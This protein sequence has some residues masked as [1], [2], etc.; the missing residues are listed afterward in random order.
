MNLGLLVLRVVVGLLFAGHG[1]QKLFGYFGGYGLK[2]TA[3]FFEGIG[4]KPGHVHATS[5]GIMEFGGGLL[6]ALG[7]ITP[8]ASAALIA[9]MTAA[10]ITVHFPKGVWVT[11]GGYEYNLVLGAVAFALA[12][13]GSGA[14][15]LDHA[16]G[17]SM[18]GVLWALGALAVGALGGLGAVL[19][20]RAVSRQQQRAPTH[21]PTTA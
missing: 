17:I 16:F 7:L 14:W 13:I 19:G 1:A 11:D 9:V 5:A 21:R 4:L 10:V 12:G 15:S 3:G 2:G 18:H 8:I 20:G 6:L